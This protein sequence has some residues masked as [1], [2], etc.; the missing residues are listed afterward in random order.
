MKRVILMVAAILCMLATRSDAQMM[1]MG[2]G[3]NGVVA[4]LTP[5]ILLIQTGSAMLINT[6]NKLRIQ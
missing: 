4:V 2:V 5:S 3:S 6:G 1:M